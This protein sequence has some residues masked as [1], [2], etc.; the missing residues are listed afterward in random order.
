MNGTVKFTTSGSTGQPKVIEK[1]A[2]SLQADARMLA[3]AFREI[4]DAKPVFAA[5]IGTQHMYGKLWLETL[6][7]LLGLPVHPEQI[8]GWESFLE[9]QAQYPAIIFVTTPSF[10]AELAAH[11]HLIPA[12]HNIRAII[13]SGSLLRPE[14]SSAIHTLFHLSPIEVYGST[15]TGSVAWR[16]QLNG[17]QWQVF[18]GVSVATD[19]SG[20]L[21]VT[22][23]FCV[24]T[25]YVLR[26]GVTFTDDT[27]RTFQYHGRLDRR[28]KIL[29]EMVS[30]DRIET[31]LAGHEAV[32]RCHAVASDG[33]VARIWMLAEPSAAGRTLLLEQGY[34]AFCR[35]LREHLAAHLPAQMVPRKLRIV[36]RLPYNAQ[37]KLPRADVLPFFA[38]PRHEPAVDQW[39]VQ[40]ETLEAVFAYPAD[41]VFFQ[42]HFPQAPIL[43]GVAQLFTVREMIRR[44]FGVKAD[45]SVKRLKFQQ[46]ILPKQRVSA[47]VT[48]TAPGVFSFSLRTERGPCASGVMT[49]RPE[50]V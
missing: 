31:V 39:S 44:A 36:S 47:T 32:E 7:P 20:G 27:R 49:A 43:P 17:E 19:P 13:T 48:R 35:R 5:S 38:S 25:P 40:G 22:S 24:T 29:E 12:Q 26:D 41:A 8:I 46:P 1:T 21:A 28:V 30:L 23:P 37:G 18:D 3:T 4:F 6:A 42:G 34:Q 16:Q 2:A 15:E 50:E 11:P 9:V 10:L 14:V 45:G 33:A